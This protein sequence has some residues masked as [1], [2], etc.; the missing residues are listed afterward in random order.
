MPVG[1]PNVAMKV[2]PPV[3]ASRSCGRC[4]GWTANDE[5][6]T[7][8]NSAQATI[9]ATENARDRACVSPRQARSDSVRSGRWP[10]NAVRPSSSLTPAS[11]P[12]S[13]AKPAA[14]NSPTAACGSPRRAHHASATATA[15]PTAANP[16]TIGPARPRTVGGSPPPDFSIVSGG[17]RAARQAAAAAATSDTAAAPIAAGTS[18][19]SEESANACVPLA[20]TALDP[21]ATPVFHAWASQSSSN[22]AQSGPTSEP[23]TTPPTAASPATS[24]SSRATRAAGQPMAARMPMSRR[25][26]ATSSE[27][28]SHSSRSPEATTKLESARNRPPNGVDPRAAASAWARNGTTFIPMPSAGIVSASAARVA[29]AAGSDCSGMC[30]AVVAPNRLPASRRARA[31]ETN[32]F[33]VAP[34]A[35]Q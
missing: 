24:T 26:A 35:F 3:G 21:A 9:A 23:T 12:A 1:L 22:R 34:C 28:S 18:V 31:S 2:Q 6:A 33:G 14:K 13:A 15:G 7:I 17:S 10:P 16:T 25:R 27:K 29:A 30:H 8:R 19:R 11:N 20:N 32:A 5:T 4:G